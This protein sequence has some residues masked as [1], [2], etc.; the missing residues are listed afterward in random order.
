MT[1][2]TP[3]PLEISNWKLF[4]EV[5][6]SLHITNKKLPKILIFILIYVSFL[7]ADPYFYK[8]FIDGIEAVIK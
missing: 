7:V 6:S 4:I 1:E 2:Q 3:K 5:L 8:L